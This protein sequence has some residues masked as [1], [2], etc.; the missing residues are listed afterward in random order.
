MRNLI[1]LV[2]ELREFWYFFY[3]FNF[4]F[5][6]GKVIKAQENQRNHRGNPPFWPLGSEPSHMAEPTVRPISGIF[7][8]QT[9]HLSIDDHWAK[10]GCHQLKGASVRGNWKFVHFASKNH[11]KQ[12]APPM[13]YWVDL[14]K[15]SLA[16]GLYLA[17]PGPIKVGFAWRF[18]FAWPPIGWLTQSRSVKVEALQIKLSL[19]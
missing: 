7:F 16:S 4:S 1:C 19:G 6:L 5:R 12:V 11:P 8:C 13:S 3:V 15:F 10:D 14:K 17:S 2:F 18:H 9:K